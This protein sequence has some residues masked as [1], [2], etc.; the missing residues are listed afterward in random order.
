MR[1]RFLNRIEILLLFIIWPLL[2]LLAACGQFQYKKTRFICV[3]FG[4]LFGYTFVVANEQIDAHR[5]VLDFQYYYNNVDNWGDWLEVT[6]LSK[7]SQ[8]IIPFIEGVVSRFTNDYHVAFAI[9]GL[10]FSFFMIKSVGVLY[11][12]NKNNSTVLNL[13]LV[14]F[15]LSLNFIFNINGARMWIAMWIFCYSLLAYWNGLISRSNCYI[16]LVVTIFIH[17][18]F[19]F[20]FLLFVFCECVHIKKESLLYVFLIFS[21]V[22]RP[23]V[24]G[25]VQNISFLSGFYESKIGAYTST[26]ANERVE[27]SRQMQSFLYSIYQLF[28]SPSV[29]LLLIYVRK[30]L[31]FGKNVI[32]KNM[33]SFALIV[34]SLANA[35]V[36]LLA[37]GRFF[38]LFECVAVFFMYS[39]LSSIPVGK[40]RIIAICLLPL[41]SFSI[42]NAYML[43]RVVTNSNLFLPIPFYLIQS[44]AGVI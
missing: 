43:G 28:F 27:M 5:Y 15:L 31:D 29:L 35:G 40:K 42:V 13:L 24:V 12:C 19:L 3:L 33:Y 39:A 9:F 4:A 37:V 16:L 17:W 44:S 10:C 25:L 22:V 7:G 30:G 41:L 14:I 1:G 2:G 20:V 18:S 34:Y 23:Y 36:N 6:L 11:D 38:I 21:F 8:F 26:E 32:M